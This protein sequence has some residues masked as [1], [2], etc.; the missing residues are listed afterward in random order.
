V[1][2]L[3]EVVIERLVRLRDLRPTPSGGT[4]FLDLRDLLPHFD[5]DGHAWTWDCSACPNWWPTKAGT[6]TC[7]SLNTTSCAT[8]VGRQAVV[9][10]A[11]IDSTCWLIGG[12]SFVIERIAATFDDVDHLEPHEWIRAD[13]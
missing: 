6:S 12:P 8:D 9:G 1:D 13:D 10:F 5:P 3:T 11:A 7:H 4:V 2:R